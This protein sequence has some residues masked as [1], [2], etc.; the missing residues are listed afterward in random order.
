MAE[1]KVGDLVQVK[2]L[3]EYAYDICEDYAGVVGRVVEVTTIQ[4]TAVLVDVGIE[5]YY[6]INEV[7]K[8]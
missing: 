3:A 8:V 5:L 6:D 2:H 7:R 4:G 1:I